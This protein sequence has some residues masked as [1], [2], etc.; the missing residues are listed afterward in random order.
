MTKK[1]GKIPAMGRRIALV[2]DDSAIRQNYAEALSYAKLP[3][4]VISKEEK[5]LGKIQ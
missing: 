1:D 3:K 5:A 4:Q 2:E